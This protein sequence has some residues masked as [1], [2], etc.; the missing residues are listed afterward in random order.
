MNVQLTSDIEE[1]Q[2]LVEQTEGSK[3]LFLGTWSLSEIPLDLRTS[4]SPLFKCFYLLFFAYQSIFEEVDNLEYFRG[5]EE[6]ETGFRW[7]TWEVEPL[8][9]H[10]YMAG[11]RE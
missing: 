2:D 10:F 9:T 3:N 5:V 4:L 7:K 8:P 1:L 11:K 6:S